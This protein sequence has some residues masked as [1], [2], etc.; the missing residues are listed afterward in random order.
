MAKEEMPMVIDSPKLLDVTGILR[1]A[2]KITCKNGKLM[3]SIMLLV[4][5]P[6]SLLVLGHYLLS[7]PLIIEI[8]EQDSYDLSINHQDA[9]VFMCHQLGFLLAF[10]LLSVFSMA[11]TI[12][13][14]ATTYV[15]TFLN[16]KEVLLRI[17]TIWKRPAITW[18]YAM[19]I[20]L[21]YA[22]LVLVLFGAFS[23]VTSSVA[24]LKTW[25]GFVGT[26]A[27]VFF[28]YLDAIWLL[29]IVISVVEEG[30]YGMKAIGKGVE[31]IGGRKVQGF[32]LILVLVMLSVPIY[33]LFCLNVIDDE[34]GSATRFVIGT[35]T[36]VL[37]CFLKVFTFVVFTVF[38]YQCKRSHGE[39][40]EMEGEEMYG[41]L[42]T[43]LHIDDSIP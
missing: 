23:L 37:F 16:L 14:S 7:G 31:L 8:E 22:F 3:L 24:A 12:Y 4:F 33:L 40:I 41:L 43:G 27:M 2:F 1:E 25:I 15:G 6:F 26:L 21:A 35:I 9:T 32:G 18:L 10:S 38:Y 36:I 28:L 34:L 13:A 39:N 11:T 19:L 29:G 5:F 42:S 17:I 30:C 20:T